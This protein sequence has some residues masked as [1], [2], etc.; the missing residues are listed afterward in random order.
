MSQDKPV[1]NGKHEALDLGAVWAHGNALLR[2]NRQL[3]A[4][5]ASAFVLLPNAA[6]Q[7]ALP[8]DAL[9]EGP[10]KALM[11]PATSEAMQQKAALALGEMMG[12]FFLLAGVSVI[13]AHVG[14][15]AIVALIGGKRPTVGEALAQAL[16]VIAPLVLA[17]IITF[18]ALYLVLALVQL[19]LSPLGPLAATFI[20][21][22]LSVLAM[23]YVTA[24]L[25]LTLPVMVQEWQLN[26]IKALLRSW[27]LTAPH[28]GNVFGFWML[29]AVAW[30]VTFLMQMAVAILL[31][32]IPG[33]GPTATL[34]QGLIGGSFAM[35]WGA[36]YCVMGVA[37]YA[38]LK[39]A[40][41]QEIAADFE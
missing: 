20:G 37:M 15:A 28:A 2:D 16:R 25:A 1:E 41:P 9:M 23:F 11:D 34:I 29:M 36:T 21:V 33:P 39:G 31:S 6:V 3:I 12:P 38:R 17:A 35:V 13:I 24:R 4:T 14:Y 27:R 32:S 18:M 7:F 30:F 8:A 19:A 40:D 26:P 22:I 5:L 10:M